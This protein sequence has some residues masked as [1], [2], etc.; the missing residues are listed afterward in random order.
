MYSTS[1]NTA[2]HI[3]LHKELCLGFISSSRSAGLLCALPVWWCAFCQRR[4]DTLAVTFIRA[5][6]RKKR[7]RKKR[8]MEFFTVTPRQKRSSFPSSF[9]KS[10]TEA[11]LGGFCTRDFCGRADKRSALSADGRATRSF[12]S[13]RCYLSNLLPISCQH[14]L[15]DLWPDELTLFINSSLFVLTPPQIPGQRWTKRVRCLAF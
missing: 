11:S 6:Q 10:V 15:G 9:I 2:V 1:K 7:R 8:H 14:L 5:C 13:P 4:K 12:I 3:N